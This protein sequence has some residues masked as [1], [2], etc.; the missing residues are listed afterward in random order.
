MSAAPLELRRLAD[1]TVTSGRHTDIVHRRLSATFTEL[2]W[3]ECFSNAAVT[4]LRTVRCRKAKL[5]PRPAVFAV[6]VLSATPAPP[7]PSCS[8]TCASIELEPPQSACPATGKWL[9]R[10]PV[11]RRTGRFMNRSDFGIMVA[12]DQSTARAVVHTVGNLH[13]AAEH[14]DERPT[15]VRASRRTGR[16]QPSAARRH[17]VGV[18]LPVAV[19]PPHTARPRHS[20]PARR[21]GILSFAHRSNRTYAGSPAT[22]WCPARGDSPCPTD[23][24]SDS[25]APSHSRLMYQD[26][27]IRLSVC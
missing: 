22:G 4:I 1:L 10:A 16:A 13:A 7:T 27:R 12:P 6:D 20:A 14:R 11:N 18:E 9:L 23:P 8:R 3:P 17:L 2:D 5:W 21:T 26:P 25:D 24:G 15:C 19:T